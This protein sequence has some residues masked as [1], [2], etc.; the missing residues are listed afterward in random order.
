MLFYFSNDFEKFI[1][2]FYK[3]AD[4]ILR[5]KSQLL[6]WRF[7]EI[8]KYHEN[9]GFLELEKFQ[10]R[11]PKV[12]FFGWQIDIQ[13]RA[14]KSWLFH[15]NRAPKS[16]SKS[17][18]ISSNFSIFKIWKFYQILSIFD[19]FLV[20]FWW[21]LGKFLWF[22]EKFVILGKFDKKSIKISHKFRILGKF[23]VCWTE[24]QSSKR[25]LDWN[26]FEI[27]QKTRFRADLGL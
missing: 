9:I 20:L 17:Y 6:F 25:L 15:Q 23:C 16:S 3:K 5:K 14:P 2:F 24:I 8:Q 10:N 1:K 11:A 19:P 13:N 21:F 7:F 27:T 4:C 26:F 12:W 22:F 18:K